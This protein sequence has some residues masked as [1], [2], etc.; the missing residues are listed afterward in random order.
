MSSIFDTTGGRA[1]GSD[2]PAVRTSSVLLWLAVVAIAAAA[3]TWLSARALAVVA[4]FHQNTAHQCDGTLPPPP[5]SFTYAWAGLAASALACLALF[6]AA[7][8]MWRRRPGPVAIGLTTVLALGACVLLLSAGW[9][10]LDVHLDARPVTRV[11][12]G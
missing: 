12:G 9:T 10:V 6:P 8:A 3:G 11:C 4:S 5:S 7:R 2:T 1:L